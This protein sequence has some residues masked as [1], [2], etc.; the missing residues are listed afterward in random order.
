[1]TFYAFT[2]YGQRPTAGPFRARQEAKTHGAKVGRICKYCGKYS[3]PMDK[4]RACLC[5][6]LSG[7]NPPGDP[8]E[9][10]KRKKRAKL[11]TELF[12]TC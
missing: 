9:R 12:C 1:M 10:K 7:I 3:G 4:C 5:M 2:K 11:I 6:I 8:P